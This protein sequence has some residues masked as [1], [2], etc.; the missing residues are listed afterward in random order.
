MSSNIEINPIQN[1]VIERLE[2]RATNKMNVFQVRVVNPRYDQ[3]T[4]HFET[5][6]SVGVDY[7]HNADWLDIEVNP[8]QSSQHHLKKDEGSVSLSLYH[9]SVYVL[10]QRV[11]IP[12]GCYEHPTIQCRRTGYIRTRYGVK[13]CLSDRNSLRG[14]YFTYETDSILYDK[15]KHMTGAIVLNGKTLESGSLC[16]IL[17]KAIVVHSS[18]DENLYDVLFNADNLFVIIDG[19]NDKCVFIEDIGSLEIEICDISGV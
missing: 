13:R 10:G 3:Y 5:K 12:V 7:L 19:D 14:Y 17:H 18:P 8:I 16:D 4:I 11:A 15:M 1:T 9:N 6:N 2:I